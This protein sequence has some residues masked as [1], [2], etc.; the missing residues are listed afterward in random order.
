M[1]T[2]PVVVESELIPSFS[3]G[4]ERDRELGLFLCLPF[5]FPVL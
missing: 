3:P 2:S 5:W 4:G 1:I